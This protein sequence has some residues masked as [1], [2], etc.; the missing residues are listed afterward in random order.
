MKASF[1]DYNNDYNVF[2]V[3]NV[4]ATKDIYEINEDIGSSADLSDMEYIEELDYTGLVLSCYSYDVFI[5]M[6]YEDAEEY[7]RK[8]GATDDLVEIDGKYSEH[9]IYCQY[10]TLSPSALN[11]SIKEVVTLLQEVFYERNC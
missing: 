1:K 6:P 7:T 5:P 8:M 10:S 11:K 3:W 9:V 4:T 2:T